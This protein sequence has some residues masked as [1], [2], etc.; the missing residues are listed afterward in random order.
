[1]NLADWLLRTARRMPDAPALL[2][3]DELVATYGEFAERAA[4]LGRAL[5][6]VHGVSPGDRVAIFMAN[7][8]EYL[9]IMY[10]IWWAGAA[11]VPINHKLHPREAAYIIQD[12]GADL[13]FVSEG[14]EGLAQ[15]LDDG[16]RLITAPGEAF[17]TLLAAEPLTAPQAMSSD[18]LAWLFYTSGTTGNPKGVMLSVANLQAMSFAYFVDV[19][20]V[21]TEDAALYAAP[22]SH[23]AGLYNFMH[24]LRGARHVIPKSSG[25]DAEEI[26]SLARSVGSLSFFAAPT[27]VRRLVQHAKATGYD[28]EGIRTIVYGGGPMYVADIEEAVSLFGPRFVQ[29]YG[30]GES[31]MTITALSR[32]LVADRSHPRWKE[33]LGS[34]GT[35]QSCVDVRV[36]DGDG[37]TLAPGESGEILVRGPSVMAGYWQNEKASAGSL[38]DGWLWTGDV[39]AMDEDGFLTLMDRSKDVII[40]GGTNIYPREVEEV[41]LRHPAVQ[42]VSVVGRPSPEWGE[43]VVA[44]VVAPENTPSVDELDALCREEIARFKRPKDY[45]FLNELPKNNYGKVLKIELRRLLGQA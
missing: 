10:G 29:I 15:R 3:G 2:R 20:D 30:Q 31:P 4:R 9:E 18:G 25:F 35:A 45:V 8:T 11:A 41:L 44:F 32:D 23:G 36:A 13:V 42:E 5:K 1:M 27:M 6:E 28:G 24:V 21:R 40:S 14:D 17:Q 19:D 7:S 38:R 33:R 37:N 22:M 39:G 12:S 34:V 16:V 43:D 26:A